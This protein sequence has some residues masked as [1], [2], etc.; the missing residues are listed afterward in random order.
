MKERSILFS[1]AMV[2]A[3][4]AGT[5]RQTRR[6]VRDEWWRCLDADDERDRATAAERSPYGV[7]GDRLWVKETWRPRALRGCTQNACDRDDVS[8]RYTA[9]DIERVFHESDVPDSWTMPKAAARGNVSPLF[10]PRWASRI[11][12]EVTSVRVERLQDITEE[13][14]RAEGLRA[15]RVPHFDGEGFV[16]PEEGS[17][18][19]AFRSIWHTLNGKRAPWSSNP[20]CWVIAFRRVDTAGRNAA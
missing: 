9:D 1:G 20:F 16:A 2:R 4:L 15:P 14:A 6:I 12:L 18:L 13:D 7:P 8:M 19:S 17:A 10:M 11:T 3:I 5:K